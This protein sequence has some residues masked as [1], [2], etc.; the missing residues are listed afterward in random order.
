MNEIAGRIYFTINI[1]TLILLLRND[2]SVNPFYLFARYIFSV[3][4][5]EYCQVQFRLTENLCLEFKFNIA[6]G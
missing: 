1:S 4:V 5:T 3:G 6:R 2:V